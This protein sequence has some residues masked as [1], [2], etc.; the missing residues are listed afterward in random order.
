MPPAGWEV[1]VGGRAFPGWARM[2]WDWWP[3]VPGP[4][5]PSLSR[6]FSRRVQ[7]YASLRDR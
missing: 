6:R 2:P 4:R 3:P 5:L 7:K 1:G